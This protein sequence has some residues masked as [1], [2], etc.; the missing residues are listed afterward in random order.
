MPYLKQRRQ[1]YTHTAAAIAIVCIEMSKPQ[2][3]S[4]NH[5]DHKEQRV[6]SPIEKEEALGVAR[7]KG[8]PLDW[9]VEW[10]VVLLR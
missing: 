7:L 3:Q 9:G 8:L 1:S 2:R 5:E 10:Y 6:L 4:L